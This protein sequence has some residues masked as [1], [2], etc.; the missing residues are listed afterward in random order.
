MNQVVSDAQEFENYPLTRE[1]IRLFASLGFQAAIEGYTTISMTIFEGLRVLRG[2]Q[3]W[4]CIGIAISHMYANRPKAASAFLQNHG[5]R[6]FPEDPQLK[7]FLS[8][9]YMLQKLP[10][11]ASSILEELN[12]NDVLNFEDEILCNKIKDQVTEMKIKSDFPQPAGI[13][14]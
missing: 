2:D 8:L 1:E 4:I 3:V 9:A 14:N 11:K 13:E 10:T 12:L 6:I 7:L 5:L